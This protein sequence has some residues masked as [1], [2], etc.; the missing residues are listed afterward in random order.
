[1][2]LLVLIIWSVLEDIPVLKAKC[3][4]TALHLHLAP[5]ESFSSFLEERGGMKSNN[6]RYLEEVSTF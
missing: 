5:V 4:G 2:V 3:D 1:M 6:N